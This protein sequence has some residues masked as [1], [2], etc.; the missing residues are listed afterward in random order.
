MEKRM[1][2]NTNTISSLDET[3]E[4]YNVKLCGEWCE[5]KIQNLHP[6]FLQVTTWSLCRKKN[7]AHAA[8]K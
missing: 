7:N 5:Y 3:L 1:G 4:I 6:C 2:E 8:A